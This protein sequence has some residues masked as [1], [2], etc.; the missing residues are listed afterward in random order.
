MRVKSQGQV[1]RRVKGRKQCNMRDKNFLTAHGKRIRCNRSKKILK[2]RK[3]ARLKLSLENKG[4]TEQLLAASFPASLL[5]TC[6]VASL[7]RTFFLALFSN[8]ESAEKYLVSAF[9]GH[10]Q[11]VGMEASFDQCRIDLQF[12][13]VVFQSKIPEE[14]N[15]GAGFKF[16]LPTMEN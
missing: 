5:P 2:G 1:S 7:M 3:L 14:D 16:L 11:E 8:K 15:S 4:R 9:K 6:C 12:N 13:A 10:S